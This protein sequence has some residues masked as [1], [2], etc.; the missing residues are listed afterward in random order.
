MLMFETFKKLCCVD[1]LRSQMTKSDFD[2]IL[3]LKINCM[4]DNEEVK[5]FLLVT[6]VFYPFKSNW[7]SLVPRISCISSTQ[8]DTLAKKWVI[9]QL[10]GCKLLNAECQMADLEVH[11]N[12]LSFT[13]ICFEQSITFVRK[14]TNM[15]YYCCCH[16]GIPRWEP[17]I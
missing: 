5:D 12:C 1:G 2:L 4:L 15:C 10:M 7:E 14:I 8:A 16:L 9:L 11:S 6:C 17:T 13:H 3:L